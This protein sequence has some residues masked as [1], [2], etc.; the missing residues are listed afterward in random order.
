MLVGL[1]IK[2]YMYMPG[3]VHG[4]FGWVLSCLA[5]TKRTLVGVM[6]RLFLS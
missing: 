4:V 5:E 2:I 3:D 1:M 6:M